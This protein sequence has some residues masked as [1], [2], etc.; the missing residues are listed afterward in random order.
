MLRAL[1]V[2][3]LSRITSIDW[4]VGDS[5]EWRAAAPDDGLLSSSHELF[6]VRLEGLREA[7]YTLQV[8]LRD[9]AGNVTVETLP[10][11]GAGRE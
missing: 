6:T 8:R 9:A 11:D 10:L 2:D 4:R 3:S 5:G 7:D 1:A